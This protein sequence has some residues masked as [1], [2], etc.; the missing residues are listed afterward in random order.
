MTIERKTHNPHTGRGIG[1][2]ARSYEEGWVVIQISIQA[3]SST[4]TAHRERQL[5]PCR[6][7]K[8]LSSIKGRYWEPTVSSDQ[9]SKN[10]QPQDKERL[11]LQS[12][13]NFRLE[14]CP[15]IVIPFH[16]IGVAR[17]STNPG[18]RPLLCQGIIEIHLQQTLAYAFIRAPCHV[19]IDWAWDCNFTHVR[20]VVGQWEFFPWIIPGSKVSRFCAPGSNNR[21][22]QK[23]ATSTT[24]TP[25]GKKIQL[26]N[27]QCD[28]EYFD[29]A[30]RPCK[31][32][33]SSSTH[34]HGSPLS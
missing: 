11:G 31:W 16:H 20:S 28:W 25:K 13:V 22:R 29:P 2:G 8:A 26:G 27:I 21:G 30:S 12:Q 33:S 19:D 24:P 32:G 4:V 34:S 1:R 18:R 3:Q 5:G 10:Q 17:L 14:D 15:S 23:L 6:W 7:L 9:I